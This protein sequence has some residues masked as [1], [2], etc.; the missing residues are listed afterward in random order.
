MIFIRMWY[1]IKM[2]QIG[3]KDDVTHE[4]EAGSLE[5]E[6]VHEM[7]TISKGDSSIRH[8]QGHHGKE[9]SLQETSL[10]VYS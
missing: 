4:R 5:S 6:G 9:K 10:A 7:Y 1:L 3:F 8:E 2:W